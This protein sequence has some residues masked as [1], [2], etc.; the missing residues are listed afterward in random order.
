MQESPQHRFSTSKYYVLAISLSAFLLPI[1]IILPVC[2][3]MEG[4]LCVKRHWQPLGQWPLAV[5]AA[6]AL[7]MNKKWKLLS[8]KRIHM[9][10]WLSLPPSRAM[11]TADHVRSLD[12][13]FL[14]LSFSFSLQRVSS[15]FFHLIYSRSEASPLRSFA[16]KSITASISICTRFPAALSETKSIRWWVSRSFAYHWKMS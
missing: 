12:D 9:D 6:V 13:L 4:V 15:H 5:K 10:R 8:L 7:A 3:I 1:W 16:V 11:G 14:S 2:L